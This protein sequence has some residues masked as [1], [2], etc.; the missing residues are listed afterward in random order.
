MYDAARAQLPRLFQQEPLRKILDPLRVWYPERLYT[1]VFDFHEAGHQP[2]R[3]CVDLGCGDGG[4]TL[5]LASKFE[6]VIGID[7]NPELLR[8]TRIRLAN[9]PP[10]ES[11]GEI[12]YFGIH[13][14][15]LYNF[16][17][18][19]VDMVTAAQSAHYF[20]YPDIWTEIARV[21]RP[22]GTVAFWSYPTLMLPDS[23][24]NRFWNDKLLEFIHGRTPDRLGLHWPQP[25]HMYLWSHYHKLPRPPRDLFDRST[26]QLSHYLGHHFPSH[27]ARTKVTSGPVIHT[28]NDVSLREWEHWLRRTDAGRRMYRMEPNQKERRRL[29][30]V[31]TLMSAMARETGFAAENTLMRV[32]V[33]LTLLLVRKKRLEDLPPPPPPPLPAVEAD[34]VRDR[35]PHMAGQVG[36]ANQVGATDPVYALFKQTLFESTSE[37]GQQPLTKEAEQQAS[38]TDEA[39]SSTSDVEHQSSPKEEQEHEQQRPLTPAPEQPA[40]IP[41]E[42][43]PLSLKVEQQASTSAEDQAAPEGTPPAT[44]GVADVEGAGSKPSSEER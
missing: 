41:E 35:P 4:S 15:N 28:I 14:E 21:L 18:R 13:A 20:T 27:W 42:Q 7:S 2:F 43:H 22:G 25:A 31:G 1:K 5:T 26:F 10:N 11:R 40:P 3:R 23:T 36:A 16:G 44:K 37:A 32:D 30:A 6:Q 12:Q 17:D 34:L 9:L 8:A 19:S 39:R 38:A 33:P 24:T 29:D